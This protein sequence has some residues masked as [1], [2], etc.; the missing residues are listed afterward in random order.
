MIEI[1]HTE[2][3]DNSNFER[4]SGKLICLSC[5]KKYWQHPYCAQA[6]S[7]EC[8]GFNSY[9]VHVLCDGRHVKL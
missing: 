8:H 3:C 1:I 6:V 4:T 5:N 9:F 7:E 2:G